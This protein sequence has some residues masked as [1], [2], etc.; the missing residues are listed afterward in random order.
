MKNK[1]QNIVSKI[2]KTRKN[3]LL[4]HI[5]N[6]LIIATG[7]SAGIFILFSF[8]EHFA[9]F[10]TIGRTIL[11]SIILLIF[12]FV[13]GFYGLSYLLKFLSIKTD[14]AFDY[15]AMRIGKKFPELK[16][17]LS[18]AL[19]LYPLINNPKGNSPE[20]TQAVFDEISKTS[21]NYNFNKIVD[22]KKIKRNSVRAL[23]P[24][25]LLFILL[26]TLP[27]S[28]GN[29]SYR[30]VNFSTS[31]IPPAPFKIKILEKED[32]LI[33]GESTE[34][35]VMTEGTPPES[36][37]LLI[38]EE[39]QKEFDS[40]KLKL[41]SN[42]YNY[43]IPSL[44]NSISYY[45]KTN[46]MGS[47][48]ITDIYQIN[49][50][51]LP[52]IETF[53]G[54]VNYPDYTGLRSRTFTEKDADISG[55]KGSNINIKF[56]SNKIINKGYLVYQ[57]EILENIEDSTY[58]KVVFDTVS[59]DINNEFPKKAEV[60][61]NIKNSGKYLIRIFDEDGEINSKPIEY[62]I[63]ALT[64]NFP[65]ISL[66]QPVSDVQLSKDALLPI[67]AILND[68]YGFTHLKLYYK[69]IESKFAQPDKDFKSINIKI[70]KL[71]LNENV[72]YIWNLN[73]IDITPEDK[74]EFYLEVSDNDIVNGPKKAKTQIIT[75]RLP[76]IEEILSS[77]DNKQKE[78][79]KDLEEV[80]KEADDLSK[81]IEEF[82]R[83]MEK[84]KK[85]EKMTWEEK[86]K[87]QDIMKKQKE[88]REKFD[89][90]RKDIQETT[91][92]MKQNN[93]ISEETLRKYEELQRLMQEVNSP[94]LREMN[95][96]MQEAM[97]NMS[98]EEMQKAM[99]NFEF[100]EEQ[101]QKSIE[102]TKKILQ[103]MKAEQKIDALKKLA[104]EMTEEQKR[105]LEETKNTDLNNKDKLE[106]LKNRQDKLSEQLDFVEKEMDE[107]EEL[108]K[109]IGDESLPMEQLNESMESLQKEDTKNQ[110]QQANQSLDENNK[111]QANQNQ[112][113]AQNN[114][115]EF[116]KQM[117]NLK[118]QM[119]QMTSQQAIEQMEKSIS[120]LLEISNQQESLK[121]QTVNSNYNSTKIPSLEK[122][123]TK[124]RED[125][126]NVASSMSDLSEKSFAI[127]PEM[128]KEMTNAMKGMNEAQSQMAER[129]MNNAA[130]AQSNAMGSLNNAISQMQSML[131]AMQE[132]GNGT[133]PNPGGMGQG[134]GQ[135]NGQ[136]NQMG[137]SQQ[138][139]QMAAQQMQLNQQLKQMQN[140]SGSS[141]GMSQEKQAE[142][143]RLADKQGRAKQSID[144]LAEQE[145]EFN[146]GNSKTAKELDDISKEMEEVIQD[147]QNN[148][149]T[150]E[151]LEKQE[152]ILSRLLD[153]T[154]SVHER[155]FQKNR[156]SKEGK[157]YD[158]DNPESLNFENQKLNQAINELLKQNRLKYSKDYEILIKKYFN[159]LQKN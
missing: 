88:V 156:E 4:I 73:E 16:D 109:E 91:E 72:Y 26:F 122:E 83:Y 6:A 81:E 20:L 79:E 132:Q 42:K 69:M 139:Q 7:F 44:K 14:E 55:L 126:M 75:V 9:N 115:E 152:R 22:T 131:S 103:R 17:K 82:N 135:G 48:I 101:F 76:S 93:L 113:N 87:A 129:R 141:G 13:F 154:R 133:C 80:L 111:K 28:F 125:L 38:K 25:L 10:N 5:I 33:R 65:S 52:L 34:I 61:F 127:T 94:E 66:V 41:D 78:I 117:N 130:G 121:N 140:G 157:V 40:I 105:I 149:I 68:D 29:A 32:N 102:R 116:S 37:E 110:M 35:V 71:S 84:K 106:N 8:I 53:S 57:Q 64:D 62:G 120:D 54:V 31:F 43:F 50:I 70:D 90:I 85:N 30:L 112:Q 145:K 100:N 11:F 1:Y 12:A 124:L 147:I 158:V 46:W 59:I 86:K 118:N 89:E 21:E 19:Q 36:I 107:L 2:K 146:N 60:S 47:N 77:A 138:M 151:T 63:L 74:Y 56:S 128:G 143:G 96:K 153:A 58:N 51:E 99:E 3:E 142:M 150:D 39:N 24:L 136:G 104:D 97:Q 148:N 155:D 98:P 134:Q 23:L 45:A 27:G 95:R 159:S 137:F 144:E 15:T 114:L 123:Q 92:Q 18:N 67:N 49:V 108:M 119:E